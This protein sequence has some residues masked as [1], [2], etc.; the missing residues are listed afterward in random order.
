MCGI[1]GCIS[2]NKNVIEKLKVGLKKLEYRGYDSAGISFFEK[3]KIKTIK[4]VG[5]VD[6][7]FDD[8][9]KNADI[10]IG[11]TRWATHGKPCTAN[12]HPHQS[13]NKKVCLVHNG[14]IENYIELKNTY[15]KNI[16]LKS[17]TDTE[18]ACNL[19][20]LFLSKKNDKLFAINQATKLIKGSFAFAI[21]FDDEPDKIY[22]AKN[23]SPLLIGISKTENYISSDILGFC[24]SIKKYVII[25]NGQ[26]GYLTQNKVKIYDKSLNE[27]NYQ[28][29]PVRK[30]LS[31]AEKQCYEYYM[32]KE[33]N[34]IKSRLEFIDNLYQSRK[35]PL[36][37]LAMLKNKSINRI[38]LVGCG[39]SFHACLVAEK[40]LKN[41]GFD[42]TSQIA[43]EFIYSPPILHKDVLCIF[44]SQSG[45]TADTISAIN[46]AKQNGTK[47][48]G[49][50]N[51]STSQIASMCDFVLPICSGP[52]IAVASTKAY[53]CQI[54][55][56][57]LLA[58][59]LGGQ[60]INVATKNI[61]NISKLIDIPKF[62]KQ[63]EPL[64]KDIIEAK[65]VFLCGKNFDYVTSLESA[66][67]LKEITYINTQGIASGELKHG[68]IALVDNKTVVFAFATDPDLFEK[69]INIANQTKA[70]GAKIVA[71]TNTKNKNLSQFDYVINLPTVEKEL[72]PIVSIIP[73]QL[74]A[75]HTT[76]A[77]GYN[78]DKPRN[79]A[80]SVTVE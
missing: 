47:T 20:E 11:H 5:S 12:S 43:S 24:N 10:G 60:D 56:L 23:K 50:T 14:I 3:G 72:S 15:L 48:L 52:E 1:I 79:L 76:L 59:F 78:P 44:V 26:I 17:Q 42:A 19:I 49:I 63:I 62:E 39:T 16:K 22:F 6:N 37:Q 45:E 35:S 54:A 61:K 69:T 4:K 68:T 58:N 65:N 66:L 51:V 7:L 28:I 57:Y 71:I 64:I 21:L 46:V 34:E 40:F 33:I 2:K 32:L 30:S 38:W 13:K 36:N 31:D 9:K 25:E 74:L 77:L 67:K 55:V 73:M 41:F 8:I 29:K 80:K 53:N 75:Y 18:I 27:I 70:R